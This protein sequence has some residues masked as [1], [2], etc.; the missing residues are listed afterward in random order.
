MAGNQKTEEQTPPLTLDDLSSEIIDL[1]FTLGITTT[2]SVRE[3]ACFLF[4]FTL[5]AHFY[6][7]IASVRS[8]T[9]NKALALH[10][11]DLF[12]NRLIHLN[13]PIK[14]IVQKDVL[15]LFIIYIE[16]NNILRVKTTETIA[17]N[18]NRIR[19]VRYDYTSNNLL[20]TLHLIC[21]HGSI[22]CLEHLEKQDFILEK[23]PDSIE[24]KAEIKK[25][26]WSRLLNYT[27]AKNDDSNLLEI[28]ITN[29]HL[30]IVQFLIQK[31]IDTGQRAIISG[32]HLVSALQ[33]RFFNIAEV[34]L[35]S[36]HFHLQPAHV[37]PLL[38]E[39]LADL[40]PLINKE[41]LDYLYNNDYPFIKRVG[42]DLISKLLQALLDN[43]TEQLFYFYED[44]PEKKTPYPDEGIQRIVAVLKIVKDS[45][46]IFFSEE[47]TTRLFFFAASQDHSAL[48]ETLF[49]VFTLNNL[50]D[51]KF[52]INDRNLTYQLRHQHWLID[53]SLR[54]ELSVK[55]YYKN[56]SL[57]DM[58]LLIKS[59]NVLRTIL[60]YRLTLT[61]EQADYVYQF[62]SFT[63]LMK[64]LRSEALTD[65]FN[66]LII[67]GYIPPPGLSDSCYFEAMNLLLQKGDCVELQLGM[68]RRGIRVWDL[69]SAMTER[70]MAM[71]A[72]LW[73]AALRRYLYAFMHQL[74]NKDYGE[75]YA[76][77][78]Q[79]IREDKVLLMEFFLTHCNPR[80][81]SALREHPLNINC[82]ILSIELAWC[83]HSYGFKWTRDLN[84]FLQL[85]AI[86]TQN[87]TMYAKIID[88]S[89]NETVQAQPAS[90]QDSSQLLN[91]ASF[92]LFA[93][94]RKE[95]EK[96]EQ[97]SMEFSTLPSDQFRMKRAK[98]E[99]LRNDDPE[100]KSSPFCYNG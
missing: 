1:V 22:R 46:A 81:L 6:H 98:I 8:N 39:V 99:V 71:D 86:N 100:N 70:G 42:N 43:E 73:S 44:N 87:W 95:T 34:L 96:A 74:V 64:E 30:P 85:I 18:S 83:L 47:L 33:F 94:K 28:A 26:I 72:C 56:Q 59:W 13:L 5:I 40:T 63:N 60:T 76:R 89:Y 12:E 92:G 93:H 4:S 88:L 9:R 20:S 37:Q 31:G 49:D 38:I 27:N 51:I 2:L 7:A 24:E 77:F 79:L 69:V 65:A 97:P 21:R 10:G 35:A 48:I 50:H 62:Y 23:T 53:S 19:Y 91:L 45:A 52:D 36:P 82:G 80:F 55:G 84:H 25:I 54:F 32:R 68:H 3:A 66:L 29:G 17:K 61:Q 14:K 75:C 58:V 90:N 16:K 41:I 78:F 15:N 67:A 57:I 11:M